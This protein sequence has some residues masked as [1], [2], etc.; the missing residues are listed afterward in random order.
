MSQRA[1][2]FSLVEVM[3]ALGILAVG[4]LGTMHMQI[5]SLS[6]DQSARAHTRAM[7]LARELRAGLEALPLTDARITPAA[8]TTAPPSWFAPIVP[9]F[10]DGADPNAIS[11]TDTSPIPGVTPDSALEVDP[12]DASR[13]LYRRRWKVWGEAATAAISNGPVVIMVSV[14][15]HDKASGQPKEVVVYTHRYNPLLAYTNLG[16]GS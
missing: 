13:R 12:L 8:Y 14:V 16:V 11:W 9:L 2:G 7:D 6:W 5:Q 4:I 3:I 10:G 1:T 15:Y